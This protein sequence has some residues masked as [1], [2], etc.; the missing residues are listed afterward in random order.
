MAE[1]HD[2]SKLTETDLNEMLDNFEQFYRSEK[3]SLP[4]KLNAQ[5]NL[6]EKKNILDKFFSEVRKRKEQVM[7]SPL[8]KHFKKSNKLTRKLPKL[9][10]SPACKSSQQSTPTKKDHS[11]ALSPLKGQNHS[12]KVNSPMKGGSC[13]KPTSRETTGANMVYKKREFNIE[14]DEALTTRD[15]LY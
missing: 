2:P 10:D 6:K 4:L 12:L 5:T 3:N 1:Q 14:D 8:Y 15:T 9:G 11:N 7:N 13:R